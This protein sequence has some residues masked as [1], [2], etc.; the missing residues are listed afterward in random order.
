MAATSDG[1]GYWFVAADGGVFAYRDAGFFGSMG[2]T[3]P[4]QPIVRMTP[5]SDGQG[6]WFVASD[7]GVVNYGDAPF[8]GSLGGQGVTGV[9]GAAA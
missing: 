6:Y 7:G 4:N 3:H 8:Y 2:G 9:V 1:G 5:T